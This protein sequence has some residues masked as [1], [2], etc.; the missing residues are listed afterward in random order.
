MRIRQVDAE[1]LWADLREQVSLIPQQSGCNPAASFGH[2]MVCFLPMAA[3]S[4]ELVC[5]SLLA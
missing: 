2:L 5:A 3:L 1:K 4:F